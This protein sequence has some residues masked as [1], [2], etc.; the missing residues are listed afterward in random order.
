VVVCGGKPN[1]SAARTP[2]KFT[3]KWVVT[4]SAAGS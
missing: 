4:S 3:R 2:S 1:Q